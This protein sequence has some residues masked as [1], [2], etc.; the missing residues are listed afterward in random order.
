MSSQKYVVT[1]SFA[2]FK[3]LKKNS[4]YFRKLQKPLDT[5]GWHQ[6]AR[7]GIF[8]ILKARLYRARDDGQTARQVQPGVVRLRA[9]FNYPALAGIHYLKKKARNAHLRRG[10]GRPR[11]RYLDA[12][13]TP[14]RRA[15][16]L[17]SAPGF[18]F[19]CKRMRAE[20]RSFGVA[21]K[22]KQRN[23]RA[24]RVMSTSGRAAA[25][26]S[27]VAI[28]GGGNCANQSRLTQ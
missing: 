23:K 25:N 6:F 20:R 26:K 17:F 28:A 16:A 10:S 5:A 22:K 18:A 4:F 7:D 2:F 15:T 14:P 13:P 1:S 19:V 24:R 3:Y 27:G 21:C 12:P 11:R 8:R 9:P